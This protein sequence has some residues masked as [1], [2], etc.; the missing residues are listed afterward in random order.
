MKVSALTF[1]LIFAAGHAT[2]DDTLLFTTESYP[3]FIFQDNSGPLR[4][5]SVDQV[6]G[7]MNGSDIGYRIEVMPWA[8]AIVLAETQPATCVFSAAQT[9]ERQA[10]FRWVMPLAKSQSILVKRRGSAVGAR[11]LDE[12]KAFTVGTHRSDYTETLL[13]KMKFPKIDISSTF[14]VTLAKLLSDRID[15]MPMSH[16]VYEQLQKR[17]VEVEKV[18]QLSEQRL[19]IACNRSVSWQMI[20]TMQT[21]LNRM[22]AD[23]TQARIYRSYGLEPPR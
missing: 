16:D 22:I 19:G 23:G 21:K 17:S 20:K 13:Q 10:R 15:L 1:G 4:G 8:R 2:A 11:T 18:T 7:I 9:P 12:T 14:D 5:I 3:P 6:K